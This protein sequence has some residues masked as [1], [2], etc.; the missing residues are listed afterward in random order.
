M[1]R[2]LIGVKNYVQKSMRQYDWNQAL[3]SRQE[4]EKVLLSGVS[5]D[6]HSIGASRSYGT[7]DSKSC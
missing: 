4:W 3:P 1:T 7:A 5:D 6:A 2:L